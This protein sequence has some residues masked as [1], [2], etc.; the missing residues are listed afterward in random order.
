VRKASVELKK[1]A[2]DTAAAQKSNMSTT[3][4]KLLSLGKQVNDT[5]VAKKSQV[6]HL[7]GTLAKHA[8]KVQTQVN[9]TVTVRNSQLKQAFGT[10]ANHALRLKKQVKDAAGA[11]KVVRPGTAEACITHVQRVVSKPGAKRKQ[12]VVENAFRL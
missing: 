8:L 1:Q 12:V 10:L 2:R 9:F 4:L 6:K 7:F 5:T 3:L 11:Q